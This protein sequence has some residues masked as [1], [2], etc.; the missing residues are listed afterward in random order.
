MGEANSQ[1]RTIR[2]QT[3]LAWWTRL[4]ELTEEDPGNAGAWNLLKGLHAFGKRV[5]A[6]ESVFEWGDSSSEK[7]FSKVVRSARLASNF[8]WENG[9][10][11]LGGGVPDAET[12]IASL[13]QETG[14]PE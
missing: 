4:I 10:I 7:P 8:D 1:V 2:A 14:I 6:T 5:G 13:V 9:E 3:F 12:L 11:N